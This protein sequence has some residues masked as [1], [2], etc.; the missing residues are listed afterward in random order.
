MVVNGLNQVWLA[1]ITYIR[2]NTGFVYLAVIL[3]AYSRRVIGCAVSKGLDTE[4]TLSA[5]RIHPACT[6]TAPVLVPQVQASTSERIHFSVRLQC[7]HRERR[8]VPPASFCVTSVLNFGQE[9]FY[10]GQGCFAISF[11]LSSV[12]MPGFFVSNI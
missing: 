10:F 7:E 2:I 3:D 9:L 6:R 1:D 12:P 4:L 5:L 11:S 8:P